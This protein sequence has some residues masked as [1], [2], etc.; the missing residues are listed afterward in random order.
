MGEGRP[1]CSEM[2]PLRSVLAQARTALD[3]M[4]RLR[5]VGSNTGLGFI[6]RVND[7]S[8]YTQAVP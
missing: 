3:E 2:K 6:V 5:P 8:A 1:T 4:R 7:D